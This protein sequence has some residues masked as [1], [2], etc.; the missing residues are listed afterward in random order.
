MDKL[1]LKY[2][3][4]YDTNELSKIFDGYLNN[5]IRVRKFKNVLVHCPKSYLVSQTM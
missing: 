1:H 5:R 2:G 3:Y 4:R